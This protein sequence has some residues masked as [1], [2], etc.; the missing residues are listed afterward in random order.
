MVSGSLRSA[1]RRCVVCLFAAVALS[2]AVPHGRAADPVL[3]TVAIAPTKEAGLDAAAHDSSDLVSLETKAPVGPFALVGRA[4]S[5]LQ[6]FTSVLHSFGYY[7]GTVA[8]TIAGRALDDPGLPAALEAAPADAKVPVA[9]TL[10]PGPRFHLGTVTLDGDVP[11]EARQKLDLKPGQPARAA[12]VLAAR[13]RLLNALLAS[14]HALAKVGLPVATL[15]P[16]Q[17]ALNVSFQVTA[18]PRVDLGPITVAGLKRTHESYIRRRLLIQQGEAFAPATIE[19]ARQDLANTG[20]FSTVRITPA[21]TLDPQG[22]LP[23]QVQVA[24]RPLHAVNLGVA[25]STDL[26]GSI[27]ASWVHRNLFGNGEQL[28]LSAAATELGGT[29]ALQPGYNVSATLAIPDWLQRDQTLT[30]NALAVR[31]YLIAY[32]RTAL[33]AGGTVTR[34]LDPDL[35][36]TVGVTGE[37]A[38]IFQ[39][40]VTREYTLLQVPLGL[41]YDNTHNL[42]DPVH[43]V[44]G[45]IS[46]TPTESLSTPSSTFLIAQ[47]SGSAYLDLSGNGRTVLALHALVGGVEGASTYAIPPDQRF[48]AGGSGTV[49]GFR[50]QS[51][52]PQFADGVPIGGTSI[53]AGTVE[54]RQRFGASYGAAMFVDAG[55]VST[56]GVPFE[57]QLQVGAGIGARYYTSFGPLRLDFAVP[58]TYQPHSDAFEVYIGIGQAF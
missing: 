24:E 35:T 36:A 52:G 53:D 22:Q 32:N 3:Y 55:Q 26:G 10:T 29:A 37:E 25:Y 50:F 4:R 33:V 15:V 14:G 18:G 54:L 8:I 9:V 7:D 1:L 38:S 30:L 47:A 28:T 51:V 49:R 45:A 42:L 23:M 41:Q 57:G 17:H 39:E 56:G 34:K 16:D 6:R 40:Y 2:S 12:D 27:T 48:Y 31:E 11:E 58:V 13:T 5:D 20:L 19:H 43:G 46:L 21:E 44:R